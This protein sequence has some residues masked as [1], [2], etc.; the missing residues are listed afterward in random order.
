MPVVQAPDRSAPASRYDAYIISQLGKVQRRIRLHDLLMASVV[1][2][3]LVVL[4]A[5]V[6]IPLDRRLNL[7][8]SWRWLALFALVLAA[9]TYV[10]AYLV[11]PLFRQLNPYFAA[12][13]LEQL[14][15][16]AKNSL[17][18]WLDLKDRPL[19]G[20]IRENVIVRAARDVG[21]APVDRAVD[22][23]RLFWLSAIAVALLVGA[24]IELVVLGPG[25][26]LSR[27]NRMLAPFGSG[28]S[29]SSTQL[30]LVEPKDGKATVSADEAVRFRV[31]VDGRVPDRNSTDALKLLY[32]FNNN[33][34]YQEQLLDREEK[35]EWSTVLT[36]SQ[37]HA[38]GLWYYITG[39]DTRTDENRI[40]VR[41][42]PLIEL[43]QAKYENRHYLE[44][45]NRAE[46]RPTSI[47]GMRG[48]HVTLTTRANRSLASAELVVDV[49]G[50]KQSVKGRIEGPDAEQVV[51]EFVLDQDGSQHEQ[52]GTGEITYVSKQHETAQN[53]PKFDIAVIRDEV[54]TVELT[55][56]PKDPELHVPA[57]GIVRMEGKATDDFGIANAVLKLKV[58]GGDAYEQRYRRNDVILLKNLDYLDFV[59]LAG[60]KLNLHP[61]DRV[62][63]VL[64]VGDQCDYP[65]PLNGQTRTSEPRYF[66]VAP[67]EKNEQKVNQ[68]KEET[69]REKRDHDEKEDQQRKKED[70]E[71]E[72]AK[73]EERK[74]EQ[75]DKGG[76]GSG[77]REEGS[78]SDSRSSNDTS[79]GSAGDG[80]SRREPGG[81]SGSN[82]QGSQPG[83]DSRKGSQ[84]KS[85]SGPEGS[86]SGG[87]GQPGKG[88]NEGSGSN[89]Q[90]AEGA[91][92]HAVDQ[93]EKDLRSRKAASKPGNSSGG[94][95]KG[96]GAPEPPDAGIAKGN[97]ERQGSPEGNVGKGSEGTGNAP[98][99]NAK[100]DPK[101]SG[102]PV[103]EPGDSKGSGQ[104][105]EQPGQGRGPGQPQH[106]QPRAEPKQ[107][108]VDPEPS[109]TKGSGSAPPDDSNPPATVKDAGAE[110][111]GP[112]GEGRAESTNPAGRKGSG[113]EPAARTKGSGSGEAAEAKGSG[114]QKGSAES[115]PGGTKDE[116][117][118][119]ER[120]KIDEANKKLKSSDPRQREEGAR[121]LE[122]L[123][124]ETKNPNL[125]DGVRNYLED[126]KKLEEAEKKLNSDDPRERDKGVQDLKKLGEETKDPDLRDF[127]HD[128]QDDAKELADG[129][130][131]LRSND[132]REREEGQRQL[133]KVAKETKS[134]TTR[135]FLNRFVLGRDGKGPVMGV[136]GDS[137][138]QTPPKLTARDPDS[139]EPRNTDRKTS[140]QK[141]G[142]LQLDVLKEQLKEALHDP[143]L[144]DQD[145]AKFQRDL[146]DLNAMIARRE[147]Q[148]EK[149]E[150][151]EITHPG[152]IGDRQSGDMSNEPGKKSNAKQGTRGRL[153][154]HPIFG[155][156]STDSYINELLKLRDQGKK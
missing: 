9:G 73:E 10:I 51:F 137:G 86:G 37:L 68:K 5:L 30:T 117:S 29:A 100:K 98:P 23:K 8:A 36:S 114:Q 12:R 107:P 85:S 53:L 97:S 136:G 50:G 142:D 89:S 60:T 151:P 1:L 56:P 116:L 147:Q 83:S 2:L 77:E 156:A 16:D 109:P 14:I 31:H 144:S 103:A 122:D 20:A 57:N 41:P 119:D 148:R 71:R 42:R 13:K 87:D 120:N 58:V 93:I 44:H 46:R 135:E 61:G 39:G 105:G 3:S 40:E 38:G 125:T 133:E 21:K 146:D 63:C 81:S 124:K 4:Y 43:L 35:R 32:R 33:E 72:R 11:V 141:A 19:P 74:K 24:G 129:F 153:P 94:E 123:A 52:H 64:E 143:S 22:G 128:I 7:S 48:A 27:L 91:E 6:T 45:L 84:E 66:V 26:F 18:N 132:P 130:K 15:P 82:N 111:G 92:S 75:E 121:E 131:K 140:Y 102:S 112:R 127:I 152:T 47:E 34:P 126:Q 55:Y 138:F 17:V 108:D 150:L 90:S 104:S 78:R 65:E 115:A 80:S 99:S 113:G 149:G 88:S 76:S 54:P 59:D 106:V 110:T 118:E 155:G 70:E 134:P 28:T 49:P 95:G 69:R 62:E 145:R 154:D 79:S 67:P 25:Q 101:S 139:G 96:P